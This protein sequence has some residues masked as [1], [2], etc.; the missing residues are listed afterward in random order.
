[1][2]DVGVGEHH[3]RDRI[4]GKLDLEGWMARRVLALKETAVH[5]QGVVGAVVQLV[6][7]SGDPHVATVVGQSR[8]TNLQS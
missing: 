8:H 5:Q 4:H 6:A 3:R 2:V 7:G 1:M